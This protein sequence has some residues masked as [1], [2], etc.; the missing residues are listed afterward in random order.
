MNSETSSRF[1]VL[2]PAAGSGRRM[3]AAVN[4]VLLPLEGK[5]IIEWTL[6]PFLKRNE[7]DPIV[8]LISPEDRPVFSRIASRYPERIF[9]VDGGAERQQSVLRGIEFLCSRNFS[10]DDYV[11]VHD[12]ARCLLDD[13]LLE[14][15]IA[16]VVKF[17]AVTAAVSVVDTLVK[18]NGNSFE[19]VPR[20]GLYSIQTPQA[21]R[22]DLLL[23]A[24]S[25][26]ANGATDDAGLV[27]EFHPVEL[28]SGDR[29]NIKV[30]EPA[31]LSFAE[32]M[33]KRAHQLCL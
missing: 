22:F 8:V 24:H 10:S 23:Q 9:L 17:H 30:T 29:S 16:A 15:V 18:R 14:R 11:I 4:K 27:R 12:A 1:G 2:I 31:D 6:L 7:C 32:A 5:A 20:D 19:S 13:R 33:V 26:G 21:F 28:V 25:S 3:G